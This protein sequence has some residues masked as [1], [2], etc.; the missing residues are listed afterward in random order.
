MLFCF[1]ALRLQYPLIATLTFAAEYLTADK[2]LSDIFPP[3]I[4]FIYFLAIHLLF[5]LPSF[6]LGFPATSGPKKSLL[7]SLT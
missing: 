7:I 3:I 2:I 6:L 4:L 1:S 5:G